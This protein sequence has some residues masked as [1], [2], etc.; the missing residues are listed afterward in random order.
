[1]LSVSSA[2][3][4]EDDLKVFARMLDSVSFAN[5]ILIYNFGRQDKDFKALVLKYHAKVIEL[6]APMPKVVEEIRSRQITEAKSDWV[7]VMDYDEVVTTK[8]AQ[9]IKEISEKLETKFSA[10]AIRRRN[11]SLGFPMRYGGFGDDYVYRLFYKKNF[12]N[13]PREIHSTPTFKGDL[14]KIDDYMEHHKDA[15]LSQM[16]AKTNRYSEVEA[17]QFFEGGLP[18]V[19]PLT[20]LR[21]S[22]MEFVRRYFLKKGFLDGRIGLIQSLYQS[23]SVFIS[24]SKLFEL[25]QGKHD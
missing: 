5:E 20:L 25:Q 13:W 8:L 9:T 16:V 12:L 23:Y 19:T 17:R 21:K 2:I 4:K 18:P 6:A 14:E 7:L 24:Y 10:Y 15:S 22:T 3:A 1:M 11:Y